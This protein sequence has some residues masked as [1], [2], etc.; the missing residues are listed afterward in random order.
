MRTLNK[1]RTLNTEKLKRTFVPKT[2]KGNPII[3]RPH[4]KEYYYRLQHRIVRVKVENK[5]QPEEDKPTATKTVTDGPHNPI[6]LKPIKIE[7]I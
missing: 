3:Y 6:Q 7:E 2:R 1:V 4:L 5:V